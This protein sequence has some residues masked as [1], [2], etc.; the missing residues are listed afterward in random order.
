MAAL[1]AVLT[2]TD[3]SLPGATLAGDLRG[4]RSSLSTEGFGSALGAVR[5]RI[6]RAPRASAYDLGRLRRQLWQQRLDAPNDPRWLGLERELEHA[7]W[8]ADRIAWRRALEQARRIARPAEPCLQQPC[9][10]GLGAGAQTI[11]IGEQFLLIQRGL[12][13]ARKRLAGG[14]FAN[15]GRLLSN[16]EAGLKR[17]RT[18]PGVTADDPNLVALKAEIESLRQQIAQTSG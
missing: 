10:T 15:A 3:A 17:L 13:E 9:P 5:R 14:K 12:R 6:E 2:L 1:V 16:A 11:G 7:R 18:G 4:A 8:Q